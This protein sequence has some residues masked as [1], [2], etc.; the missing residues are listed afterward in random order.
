M[1]WS[2]W[3]SYDAPGWVDTVTSGVSDALDSTGIKDVLQ[4]IF[5][6]VNIAP[7]S[8]QTPA[9]GGASPSPGGGGG[10]SLPGGL[11]LLGAS[12]LLGQD[13]K[14]FVLGTNP[15]LG[16]YS[17][18]SQTFALSQEGLQK[19]LQGL[20]DINN[21]TNLA[22][23]RQAGSVMSPVHTGLNDRLMAAAANDIANRRLGAY[24]QGYELTKPVVTS[25]P[26]TP[27]LL[28]QVAPEIGSYYAGQGGQA[29]PNSE[30][31]SAWGSDF[32][33]RLIKSMGYGG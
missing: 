31:S 17:P 21:P 18:D 16:T 29:S 24:L 33:D 28:G 8:Q 27:G 15:E 4:S 30:T 14:D 9:T 19:E 23:L 6:T 20:S 7:P 25:S 2:D 10:S 32:Y 11:L 5:G 13:A 26:G 1:G 22:T 3:I 12:G